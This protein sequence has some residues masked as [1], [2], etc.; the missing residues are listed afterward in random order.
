MLPR[1]LGR[2]LPMPLPPL[3]PLAAAPPRA[4]PGAVDC[5][6]DRTEGGTL[7]YLLAGF[8]LVGGFSTNEVSVV[9]NVASGSPAP[10]VPSKFFVLESRK[11]GEVGSL[12]L[13]RAND[14]GIG[15]YS[16]E[17][18]ADVWSSCRV[19]RLAANLRKVYTEGAHVHAVEEA[20]E[21]L[22]ETAKAF[23]QELEV[24]EVGLEIGHAVTQFG[25]LGF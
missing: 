19:S 6:E 9:K 3:A 7:L 25:E 24:H 5:R 17:S 13:A 15:A 22:V 12:A 18:V 4:L 21:T 11:G 10:A 8:E 1:V 14:C 16:K 23:V 20:A 2:P